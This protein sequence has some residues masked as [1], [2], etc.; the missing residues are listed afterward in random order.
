MA[1]QA[2]LIDGY[3]RAQVIALIVGKNRMM[4]VQLLCF[5]IIMAVARP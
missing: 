2:R 5:V 4:V 1:M 3:F